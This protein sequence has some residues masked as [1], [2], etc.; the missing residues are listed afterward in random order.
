MVHTVQ[1]VFSF[2]VSGTTMRF[3]VPVYA[4][5]SMALHGRSS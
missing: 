5:A 2:L 3:S 1:V 4:P